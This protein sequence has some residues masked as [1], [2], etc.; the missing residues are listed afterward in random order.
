MMYWC[1]NPVTFLT[2]NDNLLHLGFLSSVFHKVCI[3]LRDAYMYTKACKLTVCGKKILLLLSLQFGG[4]LAIDTSEKVSR[5]LKLFSS[6]TCGLSKRNS[7]QL[8]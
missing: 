2:K 7:L 3:A 8:F 4:F 6:S 1:C 5:A